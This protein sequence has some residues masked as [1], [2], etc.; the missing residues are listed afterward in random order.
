MKQIEDWMKVGAPIL[1]AFI[2]SV[3]ITGL[4]DGKIGEFTIVFVGLLVG[5]LLVTRN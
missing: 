3:V 4:L 5:Y 1:G 2:G